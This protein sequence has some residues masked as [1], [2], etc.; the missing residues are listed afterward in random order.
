MTSALNV[1]RVKVNDCIP[2]LALRKQCDD[3]FRYIES[4]P[5]EHIIVDFEGFDYCSRSF[6]HQYLINKEKISSKKRIEEVNMS[7]FIADMFY[8]VKRQI[9]R[10]RLEHVVHG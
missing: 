5:E 9:E 4:L 3:L 1:T 2:E 10:A 7:K 6:A 8:I